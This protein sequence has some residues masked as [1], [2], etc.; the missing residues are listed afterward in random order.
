MNFFPFMVAGL[1]ALVAVMWVSLDDP[2]IRPKRELCL[3][4]YRIEW[5]KWEPG[6][7]EKARLEGKVAWLNFTV[8]WDLT[9]KVNAA[10][11]LG[12]PSVR[13]MLAKHEVIMIQ[14]NNTN[15]DPAIEA[16]LK[17]FGRFAIPTD[18]LAPANLE[19]EVIILPELLT[20]EVFLKGLEKVTGG[21]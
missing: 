19:A 2:S 10:R 21:D 15:G 12:D 17:R 7:F 8:D 9:S 18:I 1:L 6:C 4:P 3:P 13:E 16:E 20:P 11:L 5:R 14:A